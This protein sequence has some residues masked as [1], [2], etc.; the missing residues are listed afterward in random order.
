MAATGNTTNHNPI[1]GTGSSGDLAKAVL[2]LFVVSAVA[3]TLL[4]LSWP[5]LQASL[6]YLPVEAA[7][8]RYW[9]SGEISADQ[10]ESLRTRARESAAIHDHQR[11]WEGLNLL[12]ILQAGLEEN[13]LSARRELLERSIDAADRSL[14]L[15]PVQPRLWMRKA[16]ALNQLSFTRSAAVEAFKTSIYTGRVEPMLFMSRLQFGYSRLSAMD[17]E[18]RGLLADQTQLAWKMRQRDVVRALREGQLRIDQV[19]FLLWHTHTDLLEEISAVLAP[20]VR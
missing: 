8:N 1:A 9:V 11:Y 12:C 13:S 18:S 4:T 15:A 6:H 2:L 14:E 17:D 5:R 7:I 16:Q 20:K 3:I 19:E 10:L